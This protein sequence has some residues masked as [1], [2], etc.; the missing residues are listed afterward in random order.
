MHRLHGIL[1]YAYTLYCNVLTLY[2][3]IFLHRVARQVYTGGAGTG[4]PTGAPEFTTGFERGMCCSFC[5]I[6]CFDCFNSVALA[7]I[8]TSRRYL[9]RLCFL[10]M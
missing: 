9:D 7:I 1:Q 6:L 2:S 4:Y 3:I 8:I 5:P 10:F